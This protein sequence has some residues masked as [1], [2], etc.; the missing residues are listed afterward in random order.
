MRGVRGSW[1]RGNRMGKQDEPRSGRSSCGG[2]V[3]RL[4]MVT[5][6]KGQKLSPK[7][8]TNGE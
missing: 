2:S 1:K 5:L 8:V 7:F 4:G 6:Q 3:L